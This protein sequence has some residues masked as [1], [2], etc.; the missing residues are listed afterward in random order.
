MSDEIK[1]QLALSKRNSIFSRIQTIYNYSLEADEEGREMFLS[2]CVNLDTIRTE[3]HKV[4]EEF[5]ILTLKLN[6]NSTIDEHSWSSFEEL[7]CRIKYKH[8]SLSS[9]QSTN[10]K[11]DS[12]LVRQKTRLPPIELLSFDG[13]IKSWP[14]F[15]SSFK[16]TVHENTSLSDSDKLYYLLGK[17]SNKAQ[18]AFAG[19]LPCAENY[20]IILK[21][22]I[23]KYE[24]KRLLA[25]SY[26]N[27]IFNHKVFTSP[28]I[29]NFELFLNKYVASVNS[30][31]RL[32]IEDLQDFMFLS[33]ALKLLDSDTIRAFEMSQKSVKIPTFTNLV[34][35]IKDQIRVLQNTG[36]SSQYS[37][38][39][40]SDKPCYDKP[41]YDKPLKIPHQ[42][43]FVTISKPRRCLCSNIVHEHLYLCPGI[44]NLNP[45]ERFN[46]VKEIRGCV[47]CLS[48]KHTTYNC[49]SMSSCKHCGGRH[50]TL[51]HF[52]NIQ[53]DS[54]PHDNVL[55]PNSVPSPQDPRP[56][57]P[58]YAAK[59]SGSL[60]LCSTSA[61][62]PRLPNMQA[63]KPATILLATAVVLVRDCNGKEH[64][65]RCLL[66]SA[67]Q[68]NFITSECVSR[69]G[70]NK[71]IN[72]N[73]LK[74]KGI[75]G[76]E[77]GIQGSLTYQFSSRFNSQC[78]YNIS[79][80]VVDKITDNL[81]TVLV[82]VTALP[83]IQGLPLA[84]ESFAKP[85]PIDALIGASIFPHLLIPGV[86]NYN[87]NNCSAPSAI[88]TVLGYVIMGSVPVLKGFNESSQCFAVQTESIETILKRFWE[89]DDTVVS[90][91]SE[92]QASQ[93]ANELIKL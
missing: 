69:L 67:S 89:M 46:K 36:S 47:S 2:S 6:P 65:I 33:I 14:I 44:E 72:K 74:V 93:T 61:S 10:D 55:S 54:N 49:K 1:L 24:D 58:A 16:T 81:P 21:T 11:N 39:K 48:I 73:N 85:G 83:F 38:P 64:E 5:N 41:Y 43:T 17:L 63:G 45:V 50:H 27:Q 29:N 76:T 90:V 87:H 82:D 25:S 78:K 7:Y 75:G 34:D 4:L 32:D 68:G 77:K 62:H 56:S 30:L 9:P 37:I 57:S 22:L 52:N 71:L 91:D 13:D 88:N 12:N 40:R 60:S 66:D 31:K 51:L 18:L 92:S 84:D 28:S 35:F 8:S 86:I 20:E 59:Q 3:F 70:L 15:Y 79:S 26:L 42:Q 80:F 23:D 53:S 19:T